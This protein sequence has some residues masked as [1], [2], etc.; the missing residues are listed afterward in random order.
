MIRIA[1]HHEGCPSGRRDPG[2]V[3]TQRRHHHG[4]RGAGCA[5]QPEQEAARHE[6]DA[7]DRLGHEA[8]QRVRIPGRSDGEAAT[9]SDDGIASC[10]DPFSRRVRMQHPHRPVHDQHAVG[11]P[12]E[13]APKRRTPLVAAIT[14]GNN[15]PSRP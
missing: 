8:A 1:D 13:A 9:G 7:V 10:E 5:L 12:V 14:A 6:L 15:A 3:S 2:M 11:E 4:K